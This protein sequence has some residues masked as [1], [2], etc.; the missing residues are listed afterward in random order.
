VNPSSG[1]LE[2]CGWRLIG[3]WFM[4]EHHYRGVTLQ[5]WII[6]AKTSILQLV[7]NNESNYHQAKRVDRGIWRFSYCLEYFI[8]LPS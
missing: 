6:L 1:W 2:H 7:G 5:T 8:L 3:W 4:Y